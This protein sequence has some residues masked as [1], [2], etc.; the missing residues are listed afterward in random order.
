MHIVWT[1]IVGFIAGVIAKLI[2]PGKESMGFILTTLLGIGGSLVSTYAGQAL[3]LYK[4]G[5]AAGFIGAIIGAIV[6]LIIYGFIAGRTR[7]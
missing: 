5:E 6:I 7:S 2:H 3:G 1:I 4:A